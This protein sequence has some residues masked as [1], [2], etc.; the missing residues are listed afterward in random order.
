MK[1]LNIKRLPLDTPG[2]CSHADVVAGARALGINH[3]CQTDIHEYV[4]DPE[5]GTEPEEMLKMGRHFVPETH[6]VVGE[7]WSF[8]ALEKLLT[9]ARVVV[10]LDIEDNLARFS[11]SEKI[12]VNDV[13]GHYVILAEIKDI[14]G[15]KYGKVIDPSKDEIVQPGSYGAILTE[16]ENVY[17]LPLTELDYIWHDT[18]KD[19]SLNDHWA[20][21]MLHPD[22]DPS[23]LAKYRNQAKI[24]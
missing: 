21:V 7:H 17:Y 22:D 13:D 11:K 1:E 12:P 2:F 16:E 14:D 6:V 15:I 5:W 9:E 3:S 20:M 8:Y 23:V 24:G 18:K 19:G 10:I 4:S